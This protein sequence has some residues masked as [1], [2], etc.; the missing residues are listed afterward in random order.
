[1]V[2]AARCEHGVVEVL[3]LL[4]RALLNCVLL[5]VMPVS[6]F[7]PITTIS[8]I[9]TT[10]ATSETPASPASLWLLLSHILSCHLFLRL[11]V[12]DPVLVLEVVV[13][14]NSLEVVKVE[15]LV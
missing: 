11:G 12:R 13:S 6:A 7:A 14:R 8:S 5:L 2:G 3:I 15:L 10:P 9:E 4:N 1:V